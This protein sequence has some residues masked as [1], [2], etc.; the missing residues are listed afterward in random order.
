M[1]DTS[2]LLNCRTGNCIGGSNPPLSAGW[3]EQA[4]EL[5]KIKKSKRSI[6]EQYFSGCSAAR[7]A[8]LVWDQG[9]PGSNPGT[10]TKRES[11]P[12]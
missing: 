4:N 9:V 11:I 12:A 5:V 7:L 3:E 6:L 2:S 8:H 1:A 10:P